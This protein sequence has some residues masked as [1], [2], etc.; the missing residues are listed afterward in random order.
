MSERTLIERSASEKAAVVEKPQEISP[1]TPNP[2]TLK[3]T[4]DAPAE[5]ASIPAEPRRHQVAPREK[6]AVRVVLPSLCS[7]LRPLRSPCAAVAA[8]VGRGR[9]R[10]R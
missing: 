6:T 3:P 5:T 7:R 9:G 8:A 2:L 10:A 1:P 4:T